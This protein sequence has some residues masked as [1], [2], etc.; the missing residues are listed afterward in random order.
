MRL[1]VALNEDEVKDII[2]AH[3]KEKFGWVGEVRIDVGTTIKCYGKEGRD[4][5]YYGK[6][7]AIKAD[8]FV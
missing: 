4:V 6:F 7:N 3:L 2:Y 5:V 1:E 8:V